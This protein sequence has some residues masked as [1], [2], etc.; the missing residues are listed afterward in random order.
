MVYRHQL[1]LLRQWAAA[2]ETTVSDILRCII[3]EYTMEQMEEAHN[4]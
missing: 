4:D 1:Q 2:E 3:S